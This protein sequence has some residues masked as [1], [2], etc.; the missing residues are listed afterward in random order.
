MVTDDKSIEIIVNGRKKFVLSDEVSFEEVVKLAYDPTPSG[1][2]I[3]ITVTYRGG[4]GRP[5]EGRLFKGE[6]V[7]V[8]EGTVFNVRVT[9]KS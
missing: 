4:A 1:P 8:K 7:K 3:E 6:S 5:P 2:S 9:D